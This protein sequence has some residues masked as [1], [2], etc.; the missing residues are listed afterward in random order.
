MATSTNILEVQ[1]QLSKL[2][3]NPGPLDGIWG[4]RTISAL[5][6]FQ[7][8]KGL[9]VDGILGPK[10]HQ[11]LFQGVADNQH[12]IPDELP[13]MAEA[14]RLIN[15]MEFIGDRDNPVILDW[16]DDLD[17]HYP[18]DEVPWCGLFVG[19]C[20]GSTLPE[21]SLPT[22]LL[23]ARAWEK[24]GQKMSPRYGAVMVFWRIS[25]QSGKG[26]VGF[27]TGEDDDAYRILGG[28]QSDSVCYEWVSKTRFRAA[29][30]PTSA[31]S[32]AHFASSR[33]LDRAVDLAASGN[34]LFA[35]TNA[36][37]HPPH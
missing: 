36:G 16:A 12:I 33:M 29:L 8:S 20:I 17:I 15:T 3:F 9:Q 25:E 26:H 28:N 31:A 37:L 35:T 22:S 21:E 10:S 5:R 7:A 32:L 2:G 34:S 18:G 23:S 11:A 6:L 14:K 27:Y 4:R 19:H 13:W 1:T 30:W 24:F